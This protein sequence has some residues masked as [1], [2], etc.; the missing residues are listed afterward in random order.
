MKK[1]IFMLT[2]LALLVCATT[3][4]AQ[5]AKDYLDRGNKYNE[6]GDY[7]KAI[8]DITQAIKLDPNNT[9]YKELLAEV[10][11]LKAGN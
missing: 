9:Q 7:D 8:A 3:A 2:A 1:I 5:D 6:E 10:Q 11:K 4:F